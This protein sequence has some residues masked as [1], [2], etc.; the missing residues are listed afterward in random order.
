LIVLF[1]LLPILFAVL[2]GFIGKCMGCSINEAGTD[3]C[4]RHGIHFG[5]ILNAMAVGGWL[6]L[7]TIP[8]GTI[9]FII[10]TIMGIHATV[11]YA[12]SDNDS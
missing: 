12:D 2:A 3:E 5:S 4:I 10:W 9:A 1:A 8:A 6:F 7:L 11:Y